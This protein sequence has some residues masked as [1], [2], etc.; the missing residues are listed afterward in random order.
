[1]DY[2]YQIKMINYTQVPSS[3]VSSMICSFFV[4]QKGP[5]VGELIICLGKETVLQRLEKAEFVYKKKFE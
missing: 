4:F 3:I 5:S 1:M 2:R